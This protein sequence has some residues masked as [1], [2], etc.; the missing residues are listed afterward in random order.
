MTENWKS[1]SNKWNLYWVVDEEKQWQLILVE[2]TL[3]HVGIFC[4]LFQ[5]TTFVCDECMCACD[6][7]V[8]VCDEDYSKTILNQQKNMYSLYNLIFFVFSIS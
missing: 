5:M 4:W 8:C 7:G 2:Y 6:E 1:N 3:V